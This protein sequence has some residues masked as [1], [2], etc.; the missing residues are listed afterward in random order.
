MM[1]L[2]E[3]HTMQDKHVT[4]N[5]IPPLNPNTLKKQGHEFTRDPVNH[6]PIRPERRSS[7]DQK[8]I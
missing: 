4:E 1:G 7:Y 6:A 8:K 3:K 5:L 2:P